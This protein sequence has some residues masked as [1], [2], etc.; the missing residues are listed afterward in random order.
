VYTVN[1]DE[2][3]PSA[4][5]G[6]SATDAATRHR[7]PVD[8]FQLLFQQQYDHAGCY[9]VPDAAA[10]EVVSQVHQIYTSQMNGRGVHGWQGEWLLVPLHGRTG[11]LLGVIWA[12]DPADRLRPGEETLQILRMFANHAAA[13]IEAAANVSA[14]RELVARLRELD[15]MK[16]EFVA[17]VSHELRTPLTSI[18]GYTE[19]LR[20]DIAEPEQRAFLDVIARSTD[21]LLSVV[22]ELLLVAQLQAGKVDLTFE[23]IDVQALLADAADNGRFNA[24]AKAVVLEVDAP[25]G[26]T[27]AADRSRIGQVLDNLV[28]NAVKFTADGGRVDLRCVVDGDNVVVEVEDTGIGIPLDEQE[29]MFTKFF[30][31]S[32]ARDAHIPGTGLGLAI[33]RAIVEA[34]GGTIGF[35]SEEAVGTIFRIELPLAVPA[36]VALAV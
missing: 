6:W 36:G 9:L 26:V 22:N 29:K 24:T 15:V 21:R 14:L 20:D 5:A 3:V 12:D 8:E 4:F 25:P 34:H 17:L 35:T 23:R 1:G 10:R 31:T 19:L 11:E 18:Q 16:D 33:T 13:A 32:N 7:F 30:R 28:S 2:L 27:V